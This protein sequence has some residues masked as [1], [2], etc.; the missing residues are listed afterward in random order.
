MSFFRNLFS[1]RIGK[2][3]KASTRHLDIDSLIKQLSKDKKDHTEIGPRLSIEEIK[4]FEER[5]G[6][7]APPSFSKFLQEFGDGAYWLYSVQPIDSTSRPFWLKKIR[8]KLPDVIPSDFSS[9]Y[10][11]DS[12]FCLMSEDSNGGSWCWLTNEKD[13]TGEYPLAYYAQF[14]KKLFYKVAS[15]TDWLQ[16]LVSTKSEVIRNLDVEDKLCLG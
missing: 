9:Q 15:F 14:E 7:H 12:L 11:A 8:P 16:I 6:F 5:S 1:K 2:D 4:S 13:A 3:D 10:E